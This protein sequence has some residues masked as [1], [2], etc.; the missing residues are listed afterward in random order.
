MPAWMPPPAAA[1]RFAEQPG[2]PAEHS[3]GPSR[4]LL[5]GVD[6]ALPCC[7]APA[8]QEAP[9]ELLAPHHLQPRFQIDVSVSLSI[10]LTLSDPL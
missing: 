7:A 9:L 2:G 1:A 10:F 8:S 5:P 4:Q 3:G 6:R